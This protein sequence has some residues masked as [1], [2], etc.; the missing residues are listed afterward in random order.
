MKTEYP[1]VY[2]ALS[3]ATSPQKAEILMEEI[4]A[5]GVNI[6]N[7]WSLNGAFLFSGVGSQ[8]RD[9]W[10]GLHKYLEKDY[11]KQKLLEKLLTGD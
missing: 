8:S 11:Y 3:F 5:A 4:V 2:E 7:T 9:Y 10:Y 6:N 1:L